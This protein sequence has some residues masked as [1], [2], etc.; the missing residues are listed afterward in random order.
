MSDEAKQVDNIEATYECSVSW[1]GIHEAVL[2]EY[3]IDLTVDMIDEVWAKYAEL[4]I[5]LKN[6]KILSLGQGSFNEVDYKWPEKIMIFNSRY[7][8][9]KDE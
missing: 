6:G 1:P 5:V 7:I 9:L 4:E 3:D 8:E 2:E